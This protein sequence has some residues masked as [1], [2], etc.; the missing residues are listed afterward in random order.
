M[1]CVN[2]AVLRAFNAMPTGAYEVCLVGEIR[3][4]GQYRSMMQNLAIPGILHQTFIKLQHNTVSANWPMSCQ[5][6]TPWISVTVPWRHG[7]TW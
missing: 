1:R 6:G 5:K 2:H 7:R 4:K 3:S